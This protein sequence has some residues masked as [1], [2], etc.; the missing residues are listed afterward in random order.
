MAKPIKDN[1]VVRGK[2]ARQLRSIILSRTTPSAERIEQ[3]KKD[4]ELYITSKVD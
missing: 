3:N 2:A 1:P 4:I